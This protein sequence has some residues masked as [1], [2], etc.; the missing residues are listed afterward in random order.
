MGGDCSLPRKLD[1]RRQKAE[2]GQLGV[3]PLQQE[4]MQAL[5]LLSVQA[6]PGPSSLRVPK[7]AELPSPHKG[8]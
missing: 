1:R 5:A 4:G 2:V 3:R 7:A 6:A 8:R